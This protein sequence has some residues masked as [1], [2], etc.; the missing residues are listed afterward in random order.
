M[1]LRGRLTKM[2]QKDKVYLKHFQMLLVMAMVLVT[3]TAA[4]L[5]YNFERIARNIVFSDA[6]TLLDQTG[7]EASS[8]VN[9]G[10]QLTLQI[11]QDQSIRPL[12]HHA[13][14][15]EREKI[16]AM[17]QLSNYH[18]IMRFVDSIYVYNLERGV[19]YGSVSP[20]DYN[21]RVIPVADFYDQEVV[22]IINN[23][24]QYRAYSPIPRAITNSDGSTNTFY[25]FFGYHFVD[26]TVDRDLLCAVIINI[27][28]DWIQNVTGTGGTGSM[29]GETVILDRDGSV[30]SNS[31][32]YPM[33][34]PMAEMEWWK[35]IQDT[36]ENGHLTAQIGAAKTFIAYTTPDA[37]GWRYLRFIP[38]NAIT[39]SID[40]MRLYTLLIAAAIVLVSVFAVWAL[41]RVIYRPIKDIQGSLGELEDKQR[42]TFYNLKQDYMRR[43]VLDEKLTDDQAIGQEFLNYDIRLP[44]GNKYYLAVV[45]IDR[46]SEFVGE[47]TLSYRTAFKFAVMNI[48]CEVCADLFDA[49]GVDMGENQLALLLCQK[50][51]TY[52]IGEERLTGCF[53]Q[54]RDAVREYLEYSISVALSGPEEG[55]S[56]LNTLYLQAS[57]AIRHRL[58][59]G[60]GCILFAGRIDRTRDTEYAYPERKEKDL[61]DALTKGQLERSKEIYLEIVQECGGCSYNIINI[62][63]LRLMLFINTVLKNVS[64]GNE[65]FAVDINR[66]EVIEEVNQAF[67]EAMASIVKKVEEKTGGKGER[68][69]QAIEDIIAQQYGNPSLSIEGIAD[70]MGLSA[71]Y[72]GRIYKQHA[73]S[74]IL[75]KILAVRMEKAQWLLV[76]TEEPISLIAQKTGFSSDSYFYKIFRKENGMTPTAFRQRGG[77]EV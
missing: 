66:L 13:D 53:E 37:Q 1:S 52:Q 38:Y 64:E 70:A 76:N 43:L 36:Q 42:Q 12:L 56:R 22:E 35:Q 6:I 17:Q 63:L 50:D 68:L 4:L 34:T 30:I 75:E 67:F 23:Y 5:F 3:I 26:K 71:S 73:L 9:T 15:S 65:I 69:V 29:P 10:Q 27:S 14:L 8:L 49:E 47:N 74:T 24:T 62:T 31:E 39:Q 57:E 61:L 11:Y 25:C 19:F 48:A 60:R 54:L 40:Q 18:H 44:A 58:F 7:R 2:K 59:A 46:H 21:H 45:R 33:L 72:T 55:I 20:E 28:T 41:N 77:E 16:I 32:Q 51:P